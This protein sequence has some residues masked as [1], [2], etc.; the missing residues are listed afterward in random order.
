M[1]KRGCAW[2]AILNFDK[3]VSLETTWIS[4]GGPVIYIC[5][6]ALYLL[7]TS[8]F[9]HM[10]KSHLLSSDSGLP[11]SST[12]WH[13]PQKNLTVTSASTKGHHTHFP[14]CTYSNPHSTIWKMLDFCAPN[15]MLRNTTQKWLC[16]LFG[17]FFS[18]GTSTEIWTAEPT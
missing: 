1:L 9:L 13:S 8:L 17:V 3:A 11:S 12:H 2:I 10:Q 4:Q 18:T 15:E 5:V 7:V 6:P 16:Y 14:P